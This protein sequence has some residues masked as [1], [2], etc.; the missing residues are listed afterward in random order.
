MS[1]EEKSKKPWITAGL[2]GATVLVGGGIA[3][4][5]RTKQP[6]VI[7]WHGYEIE[8]E[9]REIE[10]AAKPFR[11][12]V[13]RAESEDI[14]SSGI[15]ESYEASVDDAKT[16][17]GALQQLAAAADAAADLIDDLKGGAA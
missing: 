10:D 4:A 3:L 8:V 7:D 6:P 17:I 9:T 13:T 2:I 15:A 11:W 1:D 12:V 16:A 14:L 5:M